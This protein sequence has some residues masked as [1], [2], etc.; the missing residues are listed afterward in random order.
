MSIRIFWLIL[1]CESESGEF[2]NHTEEWHRDDCTLCRCDSGKTWC[3]SQMCS[4][5]CDNPRKIPG[6][7]CPVCD[8]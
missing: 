8:G 1:G 3:Q 6:Q 7:C 5:H 2:Y 4:V